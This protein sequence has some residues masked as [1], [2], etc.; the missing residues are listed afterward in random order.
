MKEQSKITAK[1]TL[2]FWFDKAHQKLWFAKDENFDLQIKQRF[3]VVYQEALLEKTEFWRSS[4]QG[5]LAEI[6]LLDQFPRNMFR[7]TPK[8][9]AAD[10]IALN[11]AQAAIES[12]DDLKLTTQERAFIYMPFM[13]S[14]DKKIHA[15]AVQLFSLKGLEENLKFELLHKKIIDRFGRYPHRNQILSRK[16]TPEEIEFLKEAQSSF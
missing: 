13:H 10:S 1:D 16:S 2:N 6:I 14:E 9:F 15:R 7:N 8:S 12:G 5:R 4:A 11:R 3:E